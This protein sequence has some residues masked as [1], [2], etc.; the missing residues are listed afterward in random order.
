MT[1]TI[2][3]D[4]AARRFAPATARNRQ[5]ILAVLERI[6]P[7]SGRVLEVASGTGEHAA[8]FATALPGLEWQPSDPDAEMRASIAAHTT[9]LVNVPAPLD[10][11][12]ARHPWPTV[13]ADAVVC[14]NLAHV[15]PWAASIGLLGG[16]ARLLDSGQVLYIYGPFTRGGRHTAASNAVFDAALRRHDP[17]WGV[18]DLDE[19][20]QRAAGLELKLEE[21]VEM[22][23]NNLSAVFRK[24]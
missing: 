18:R 23:S 14:V 16:S 8:W 6:L 9:G 7:E 4:P 22:P 5:P 10:L 11:D 2:P 24:R 21:V 3:R 19:I 20:A 12:C 13:E 17:A 1:A 15:A